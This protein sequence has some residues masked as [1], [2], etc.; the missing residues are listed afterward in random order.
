MADYLRSLIDFT[1]TPG[2]TTQERCY[3]T[4][5]HAIMVGAIAPGTQLTMRGLAAALDMSPTP[6]REAV[7]RLSSERAIQILGNRRMEVPKMT[8]AR[9]EDLVGLRQTLEVHA[10]RRALPYV[11][12]IVVAQLNDIDDRMD[13]MVAK[14]A[15]DEIIVLNQ[16][17]HK[18]LFELNPHQSA[19]SCIESVWLQIG[20]SQRA[21]GDKIREHYLVDHHKVILEALRNRDVALLVDAL[22]KDISA[23]AELVVRSLSDEERPQASVA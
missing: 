12:D 3:L 1:D 11:S 2:A 18:R 14:D 23:G 17:F 9:F 5:R 15:I 8:L 6:I 19:M 21:A 4:L 16:Q 22:L 13:E 7:R 20:P 10:A